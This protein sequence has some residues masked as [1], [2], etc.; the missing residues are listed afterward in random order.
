MKNKKFLVVNSFAEKPFGGNPAAVFIDAEDLDKPTMQFIAKQINLVE[1]VFIFPSTEKNADFYF[2]YF[3]PAE[4][5]SIAG[6]PTIAAI[7]ELIES[8]KLGKKIEY[9]AKPY[10]WSEGKCFQIKV[11]CKKAKIAHRFK[12]IVSEFLTYG[13]G[14]LSDGNK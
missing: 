11:T 13:K 12:E 6:H 7:L 14:R 10:K 9:D 1:T 4:E 5:I 2:R 8:N 3:T